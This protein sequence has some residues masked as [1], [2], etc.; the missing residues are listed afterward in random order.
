MAHQDNRAGAI[1]QPLGRTEAKV[2]AL[3]APGG[4]FPPS[5]ATAPHRFRPKGSF[6]PGAT[7]A[8]TILFVLSAERAV[9]TEGSFPDPLAHPLDRS[10]RRLVKVITVINI[11]EFAPI[12][13]NILT[14]LPG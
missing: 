9:T 5:T 8:E 12:G 14:H 2:W 3:V 6:L 4:F 11:V 10:K 7:M 13:T 1:P